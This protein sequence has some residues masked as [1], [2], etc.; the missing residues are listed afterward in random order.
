[1]IKINY[2]VYGMKKKNVEVECELCS[3]E[4]VGSNASVG[5]ER[6]RLEW[7]LLL[8][9]STAVIVTGIALKLIFG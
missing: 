8:G 7:K 3:K 9:V 5:K 4:Q 6:M 1:M 2:E